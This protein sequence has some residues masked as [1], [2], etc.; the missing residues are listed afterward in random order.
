ML[1][2]LRR[3]SGGDWGKYSALLDPL[4]REEIAQSVLLMREYESSGHGW[5]WSTDSHGRITYISPRLAAQIGF[6]EG[7]LIGRTLGRVFVEDREIERA[8]DDDGRARG[9]KIYLAGRKAFSNIVIHTQCG[10]FDQRWA[11]SGHPQRDNDGRFAG[12][13]GHA[14]DVTEQYRSESEASR[15]AMFDSLTGLSNRHRLTSQLDREMKVCVAAKRSCAVMMLDLDR[16]KAVNDT[17]GHQAGDELLKQVAQRL[18]NLIK[19]EF[20]LGRLGGDEFQIILPDIDDRGKLG[21]LAD[22][23]IQIV[24]QPYPIDGKRAVI[25]TSVGIAIAPY[26]ALESVYLIHASDLALY[27]AKHGGR[28]QFRFYSADLKDEEEERQELL[29]D[30]RIALNEDQLELHYQPVVQC[31]NSMVVGFEALMRWEHPERGPVPPSA[32]I[33]VAESSA[34]INQLGEWALRRACEDAKAW[35]KSVRVAVNVSGEQL[36][37]PNFSAS[38]VN[39]LAVSGLAPNRLEI[40]VTE[41]IFVR[42][43]SAARTTLEQCMA[44]GCGV[45]LDDFGTGYSSLSYLHRFPISRIKIDGSFVNQAPVDANSASIVRAI[46]ELGKSMDLQITA[47]GIETA[48]QREF[49]TS[50]GC[51]NLQGFLISRPLSEAEFSDLCRA[52]GRERAA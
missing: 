48:A 52:A 29:D 31:D 33:P 5:F 24:S 27:A 38:V 16:F 23:I 26:D 46:A 36:L 41:S 49:I 13:R 42:D 28:G 51:Q 30:L 15:L 14:V 44:L 12:Y 18:R 4:S 1:E 25:G 20:E 17:L 32:F 37:D 11:L 2:I 7:Q 50:H 43:D 3:N 34:L 8:E 47:E 21:E 35:P 19:D 40:E 6:E 45:A 10:K 9:L 22:K 39:A